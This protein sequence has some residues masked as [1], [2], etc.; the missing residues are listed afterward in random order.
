MPAYEFYYARVSTNEQNPERQVTEARNLGV[1]EERIFVDYASGRNYDRPSYKKMMS[2]LREGD[3]VIVSSLDRLG[4]NYKE[5]VEQWKLLTKDM[6]VKIRVLDMPMPDDAGV[7]G[8]AV[9]DII[10]ILLSYV[11]DR[12]YQS[13]RERQKAGIEAAKLRGVYQGRPQKKID[14]DKFLRLYGDVQRERRTI[15]SVCKEMK[16]GRHL[17]YQLVKEYENHEGRFAEE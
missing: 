3:T 7:M 17:Y 14:K 9:N 5:N 16:F 15:T 6:G 8:E 4:R 2:L 13:I 1:P 11:A 10:I 12:E